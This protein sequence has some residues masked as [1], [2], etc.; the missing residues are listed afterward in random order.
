MQPNLREQMLMQ[1]QV[2]AA[3]GYVNTIRFSAKLTGIDPDKQL[4]FIKYDA[5][6][7]DLYSNAIIVSRKFVKEHPEAVKGSSRHS[8]TASRM[9]LQIPR[10]RSMPWSHANS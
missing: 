6:G 5:Y 10:P 9:P 1:G 3:F 2:D 8:I 7:M 4:R